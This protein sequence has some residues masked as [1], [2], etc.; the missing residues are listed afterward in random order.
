MPER[1][2]YKPGDTAT[3]M[4]KSPWEQATAL[5]TVE[6]EGIRSNSQFMLTSTQQTV[7]VP[8]AAKD[9]PNVFVSVLLVKGRSV[10]STTTPER[11]ERSRQA[12]VPARIR[13]LNVEDAS[14]RLCR[15]RE[16]QSRGV[17][18]GGR[19]PRSKSP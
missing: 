7:I 19:R 1:E 11:R 14:K 2:T 17:Q 16:G 6:R 10:A 3:L 12:G 5:L 15:C 18:A 4:I 8:I 13:E 9:I